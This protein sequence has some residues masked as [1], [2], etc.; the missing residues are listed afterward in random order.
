MSTNFSASS[1]DS[2]MGSS[3]SS[4]VETTLSNVAYGLEATDG[5]TSSQASLAISP[6]LPNSTDYSLPSSVIEISPPVPPNS[7]NPSR[8][9]LPEL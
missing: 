2:A 3:L 6:E 5:T 1:D 8:T 7:T 4:A 9:L